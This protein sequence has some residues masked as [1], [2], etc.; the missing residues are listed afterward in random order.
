MDTKTQEPKKTLITESQCRACEK[1]IQV[2]RY[3]YPSGS[4]LYQFD[5]GLSASYYPDE[6]ALLDSNLDKAIGRVV[7][8]YEY[9]HGFGLRALQEEIAVRKVN[10]ALVAA[11]KSV[12][13]A[14]LAKSCPSC[15]GYE[16]AGPRGTGAGHAPDCP[17]DKAL[18]AA[19][20]D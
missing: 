14:G 16:H 12:E 7:A 1:D 18:K 2:Y 20:H 10:A 3:D 17:L 9:G 13:W 8:A 4:A 11:L 15:G 5:H 19:G 6:L